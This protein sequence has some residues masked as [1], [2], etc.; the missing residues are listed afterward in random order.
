MMQH[1]RLFLQLAVLAV[2][3][4]AGGFAGTLFS[5]HRA[6]AQQQ[7]NFFALSDT[8]NPKGVNMY[9]SDGQGGQVFYGENGQ[10]RLQMGTYNGGGERGLPLMALSDTSGHIRLLFRLAGEN[11]SPVMIMKDKS[12]S[13]RL[14]MGLDLG[15]SKQEPF[16]SITDASGHRQSVFGNY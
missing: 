10:M 9:V 14:V 2:F 12:G 13:D 16:L 11:E 8:K 1:R 15:G 5:G 6:E 7:Q 4:F 3:S